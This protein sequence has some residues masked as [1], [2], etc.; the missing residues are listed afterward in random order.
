MHDYSQ[1]GAALRIRA[2]PFV[3]VVAMSLR[4]TYDHDE[5]PTLPTLRESRGANR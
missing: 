4:R 5:I 1:V 2:D 3:L